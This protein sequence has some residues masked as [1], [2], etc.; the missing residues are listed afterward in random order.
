[1]N[2]LQ[3]FE[4]KEFGSVRSLVIDDEP[5]FVGK[6]IAEILGY[7]ETANMRKI[8]DDYDYM[9]I[10]P[11]SKSF[12]GFVQNGTTLE[13]NKNIQRMLLINESGLY[14]A[15]FGSKLPAAKKFKRWVTH[16]VLPAIRKNG[17]YVP[18]EV[19][20]EIER[21]SKEVATLKNALQ[22]TI[23]MLQSGTTA[24]TAS[25]EMTYSDRKRIK[26]AVGNKVVEILGGKDAKAYKET[27]LMRKAFTEIY[28]NVNRTMG[29]STYKN[30]PRQAVDKY[31]TYVWEFSPSAELVGE[32]LEINVGF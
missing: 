29:V 30:T 2:E 9:E 28:K 15:V 14:A 20:N 7:A 19:T 21:L 1:M 13:P 17:M 11:Q 23:Q 27:K 18:P 6:D 3:I 31:L 32:I 5:W 22:G 10:N 12:T 4:N 8:I 25:T 16:D 24:N 26:S